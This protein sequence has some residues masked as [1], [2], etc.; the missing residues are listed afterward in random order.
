MNKNNEHTTLNKDQFSLPPDVSE[1]LGVY[2]CPLDLYRVIVAICF[3]DFKSA[4]KLILLYF[5][6]LQVIFHFLLWRW[7]VVKPH[8]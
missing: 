4:V 2:V 8:T 6:V 1:V 7:E 5:L 3:N